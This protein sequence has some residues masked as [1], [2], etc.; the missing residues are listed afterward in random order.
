MVEM[1]SQALGND[2]SLRIQAVVL[3]HGAH[4]SSRNI[5][6][7]LALRIKYEPLLQRS[8][9]EIFLQS[10]PHAAL[11]D[12]RWTTSVDDDPEAYDV[13]RSP[14]RD[15]DLLEMRASWGCTTV[16]NALARLPIAFV[17]NAGRRARTR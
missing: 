15:S 6:A 1:L 17:A 8:S 12:R 3:I 13:P 4:V 10:Y 9:L 16:F 7:L 2:E 11:L 14:A 5:L